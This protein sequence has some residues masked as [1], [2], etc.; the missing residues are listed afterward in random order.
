MRFE[1]ENDFD[2]NRGECESQLLSQIDLNCGIDEPEYDY[3][4]AEPT[5]Q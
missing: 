3:S 5:Q 4:P 2:L 1:T